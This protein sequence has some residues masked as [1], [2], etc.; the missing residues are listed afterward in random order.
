[1][2]PPFESHNRW[3][4][5]AYVRCPG[6]LRTVQMDPAF[7]DGKLHRMRCRVCGHRGARVSIGHTADKAGRENVVQLQ[8]KKARPE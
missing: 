7:V 6:C 5:I 3:Q 8:G 2:D 4:R 1:M